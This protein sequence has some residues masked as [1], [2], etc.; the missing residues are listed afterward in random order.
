MVISAPY[1]VRYGGTVHCDRGTTLTGFKH[2]DVIRSLDLG[3]RR[4]V[5][6]VT[7]VLTVGV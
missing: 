6:G 7:G 1:T 4:D 5:Y 2:V 3:R